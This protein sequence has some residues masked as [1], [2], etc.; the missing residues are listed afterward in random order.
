MYCIGIN[1]LDLKIF[2]EYKNTIDFVYGGVRNLLRCDPSEYDLRVY[3]I[4]KARWLGI[5]KLEN[6]YYKNAISEEMI[7]KY[8]MKHNIDYDT[9]Y[10][11]LKADV[12]D[13][14]EK[15]I[16]FKILLKIRD[17][18]YYIQEF[19]LFDLYFEYK[20]SENSIKRLVNG[21]LLNHEIG[22]NN[23]SNISRICHEDETGYIEEKYY[24]YL[25]KKLG[26]YHLQFKQEYDLE[27]YRNN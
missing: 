6:W 26:E 11:K 7:L 15:S 14:D 10:K 12:L 5:F 17:I 21:M 1:I 3:H 18:S 8:C 16:I 9:Y 20:A 19:Y 24:N 13:M 4:K 23:M 25:Y 27:Y 2:D 22:V